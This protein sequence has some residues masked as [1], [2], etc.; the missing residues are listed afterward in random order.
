MKKWLVI[1]GCISLLVACSS[2]D[3]P[4]YVPTPAALNIPAFFDQ[5]IPDPIIPTDNPLT[6]EGIALGRQLFF[7]PILS[8]DNSIACADCHRPENAFS[9]PRQF[10]VGITGDKGFR[11]SMPL[12][13]LAWNF[14]LKFNWD[15]SASSL[16]DQMFGPVVNPV[17][18]DNTW[19]NVERTLQDHPAYPLLFEQAF[20]NRNIDSTMVTKALSQFVRTL[21]SGNSKFDRHLAGTAQL[22]ESEERGLALYQDEAGGDCFHCHGLPATPLWTDNSF[23]NNGLDAV[24]TDRGLGEFSGD[25]REF[26]LFRSPSLR[27]LAFTAPYMHDGRFATLEEVIDFYSEGLQFSET[28][29]PL[30]KNVGQGGVQLTP[31]EK[32]DLIAFLLTLSEPEFTTNP[33]FQNPNQ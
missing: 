28:I 16:K 4:T 3:S 14:N 24:I 17:E 15:G 22:S 20:G 21:I 8:R 5:S 23:H 10:S 11:N 31:E 12:Q 18:M 33:A 32:T 2:D 13:N 26:G 27:N 1:I 30:M 9:D 7:D 19:P 29:D 25:P 6:E